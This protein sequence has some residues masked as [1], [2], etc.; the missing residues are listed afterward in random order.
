M[1]VYGRVSKAAELFA[2]NT[3]VLLLWHRLYMMS[4]VSGSYRMTW[5]AL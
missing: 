2:G 4:F 3:G 1:G 5:G